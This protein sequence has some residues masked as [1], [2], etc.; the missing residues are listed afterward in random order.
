MI[1][2]PPQVFVFAVKYGQKILIGLLVLSIIIGGYFYW[3]HTVFKA[4]AKEKEREWAEY[5]LL[6][7]R[8]AQQIIDAANR[9]NARLRNDDRKRYIGAINSYV[10][11]NQTLERKLADTPKRVFVPVKPNSKACDSAL[12]GK[13]NVPQAPD[14]RGIETQWAELGEETVRTLQ[15]NAAEVKRM[16]KLLELA[17]EQIKVCSTVQ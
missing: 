2:I 7:E 17:Q 12:S 10:E 8:E 4:G 9:E 3:K 6:K 16:A 11:Y 5:N 13:T 15:S 14:G 1:P